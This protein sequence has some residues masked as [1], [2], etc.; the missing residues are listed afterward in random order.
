MKKTIFSL[1]I[2]CIVGI[3]FPL[4]AQ[5]FTG[6]ATYKSS[7]NVQ[8]DMGDK[9]SKAEQERVQSEI[10]KKMQKEYELHFTTNEST[11]RNVESLGGAPGKPGATGMDFLMI[12]S[13]NGGFLY[14]NIAEKR[15]ERQEDLMGKSFIIKDSLPVY[16]WQLT[17]ER[18]QIGAYNC[19]K[20]IYSKITE[21]KKFSTEMEEMEVSIDTIKTEAWFTM[22]IPVSNGPESYYGLPGLILEVKT[23]K[24]VV[25][26]TKIVLNPKEE[27]DIEKPKKGKVMDS[28]S[29]HQLS[30]EKMKEM[31]KRYSGDGGSIQIEVGG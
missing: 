26:C 22:D 19:Q 20:A 17:N 28:K 3:I 23:G 24:R 18:K 31:M 7:A 15:Y 10:S 1:I 6:I 25:I 14:K 16:E 29:F 8:I 9:V 21:V 30:E 2:L 5:K 4:S 27:V 11:W 12:S 13:N